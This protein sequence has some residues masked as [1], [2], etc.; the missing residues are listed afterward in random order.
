MSHRIAFELHYLHCGVLFG[1]QSRD[2]RLVVLDISQVAA[3]VNEAHSGAT[4]PQAS[5]IDF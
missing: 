4:F 3:I 1:F 5:A 2:Q